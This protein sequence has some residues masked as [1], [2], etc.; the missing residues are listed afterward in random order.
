MGIV[1]L[2]LIAALGLLAVLYGVDSR[3]DEVARRR[4]LGRSYR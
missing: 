3:F 1:F 4:H 2:V